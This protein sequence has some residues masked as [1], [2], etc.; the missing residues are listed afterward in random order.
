MQVT[1]LYIFYVFTY[2]SE[3]ISAMGKHKTFQE[4]KKK[5]CYSK[6]LDCI[7]NHFLPGL[8][9]LDLSDEIQSAQV[10]FSN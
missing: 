9:Q 8:C 2:F 5:T 6:I 10:M 3:N 4:K 7:I 1:L